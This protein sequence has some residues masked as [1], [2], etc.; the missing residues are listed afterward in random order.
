MTGIEV[1]IL[2]GVLATSTSAYV[3]KKREEKKFNRKIFG[4]DLDDFKM[5]KMASTGVPL[6]VEEWFQ[7]IEKE[8]V[9][10]EG[11]FRISCSHDVLMGL[12][13]KINETGGKEMN[14]EEQ[15]IQVISA[16]IKLFLRELP[17]CIFLSSYYNDF[18]QIEKTENDMNKWRAKIQTQLEK[19]PNRNVLL[20]KR[21]LGV[22]SKIA[23]NSQTNKMTAD[24]L[25]VV[26]G[27]C[28]IFTHETKE[29]MALFSDST[30]ITSLV[31]KMIET[32]S[33][34]K[35]ERDVDDPN[36]KKKKKQ[37]EK[38][39]KEQKKREKKEQK[40]KKSGK[41]NENNNAQV[42][43]IKI[44]SANG[45]GA[46]STSPKDDSNDL[47][48]AHSSAPPSAP[49]SGPSSPRDAQESSAFSFLPKRLHL[50]SSKGHDAQEKKDAERVI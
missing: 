26:F 11:I 2:V 15:P 49:A 39:E 10:T 1:G 34:F 16:L 30:V 18:L 4:K 21:L 9:T 7:R 6:I 22:L 28:L 3:V 50:H 31:A 25:A 43:G 33:S 14:F 32:H 45:D 46:S 37:R 41:D 17:D 23:A 35:M 38:E 47:H 5:K 12:Y 42:P 40:N 27:P 29:A 19:V 8:G 20:L 48:S 13:E 44:S 24:N 36:I